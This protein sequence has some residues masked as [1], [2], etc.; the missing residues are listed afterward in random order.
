M[1]K[2]S[3]RVHCVYMVLLF[4]F[5]FA[6]NAS[7]LSS[8]YQRTAQSVAAS[9]P[10]IQADFATS[11]LSELAEVYMAEADLA[12]KQAAELDRKGRKLLGWS[13]AV[14]Q[15]A[16]QLMLVME[17][18]KLGFPVQLIHSKAESLTVRVAGRAI[19]LSHPR[20]DQQTALEQRILQH[21]C[22]R[23]DCQ[24]LTANAE[25]AVPIPVTASR[26]VPAWTFTDSGPVCAHEGIQVRFSNTQ[27]LARYRAT[28]QQLLQ[29]AMTLAD[30]I[31]WQQRHG[32]TVQWSILLVRPIP[33]RP[34]HLV[35]LNESGDSILAVL[36]LIHGSEG[37]L[38]QLKPWLGDRSSNDS[39]QLIY[40]DAA[41]YGWESAAE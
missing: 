21:F 2:V 26:V 10:E 28:C 16:N 32:V 18:I 14:D 23:N 36:P 22:A 39:Q 13:R 11:G 8:R 29:E 3:S 38:D 33:H 9:T 17:D 27:Y 6:V 35:Q 20:A 41:S 31:A 4:T 5:C 7:E 24:A 37:L 34:E 12:R 19:I 15:Y 40:L 1:S 30:E 25:P